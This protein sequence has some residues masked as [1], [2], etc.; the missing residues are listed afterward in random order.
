MIE[1]SVTC[2]NTDRG[3]VV[4]SLLQ[5]FALSDVQHSVHTSES[6][7][8]HLYAT[9]APLASAAWPTPDEAYADAPGVL[10]EIGWLTRTAADW[11][12][13]NDREYYLRKAAAYDR[14]ALHEERNGPSGCE[15]ETE[16]AEAT[17]FYLLD[18]DRDGDGNH[19]GYPYEPDH[20]AAEDNPRGYVRQ[21]Y[22][23]WRAA[24]GPTP[25]HTHS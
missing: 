7:R 3:L 17:A 25:Q 8:V 24:Q 19:G 12:D 16:V 23:L 22:A 5:G 14:I 6:K 4:A 1:I 10:D 20:P 9:A 15:T 2:D 18:H 21:E 13:Q 11:H